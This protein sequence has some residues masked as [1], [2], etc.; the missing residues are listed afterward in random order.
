MVD[1]YL[2]LRGRERAHHGGVSKNPYMTTDP[3]AVIFQNRVIAD[4]GTLI[5]TNWINSVISNM[6]RLGIYASCKFLGDAN[7]AYKNAG[8]EACSKL[9]D[10]SGNSLDAVQATGSLQPIWTAS[11]QNTR[12]G[13]V[14]D[15]TGDFLLTPAMFNGASDYSII[16]G[17]NSD[18]AGLDANGRAICSLYLNGKNGWFHY[19]TR[20]NLT[21]NSRW[22]YSSDGDSVNQNPSASYPFDVTVLSTVTAGAA[23]VS[24]LNGTQQET[25][26]I[27]K[28]TFSNTPLMIGEYHH[29]SSA[30]YYF[31]G[32][33]TTIMVFSV[34]LT[35]GQRQSME[36]LINDYYAIY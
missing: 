32:N 35:T 29:Y 10:A 3:T 12:A 20:N 24:Y 36:S 27:T 33:I 15:G 7:M 9:Y 34:S 17:S 19:I 22:F 8:S 11:R 21:N 13:L 18:S 23:F 14:F 4:G 31:K 28:A 30:F 26:N 6:K 2:P 16:V 25:D 5:D 1:I